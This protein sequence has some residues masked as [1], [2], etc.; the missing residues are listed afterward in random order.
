MSAP[1]GLVLITSMKPDVNQIWTNTQ[2]NIISVIFLS[3][4]LSVALIFVEQ[5]FYRNNLVLKCCDRSI[6]RC[7]YHLFQTNFSDR[8]G[9]GGADRR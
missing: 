3:V 5:V 9:R 2:N 1:A 8:G 7:S 6:H 4:L